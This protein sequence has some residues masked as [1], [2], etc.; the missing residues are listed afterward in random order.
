MYNY[1]ISNRE[2]IIAI[3]IASVRAVAIAIL[4]SGVVQTVIY[5]ITKKIFGKGYSIYN[6]IEKFVLEG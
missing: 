1:L 3:L 2:L 6:E 5:Q 4:F